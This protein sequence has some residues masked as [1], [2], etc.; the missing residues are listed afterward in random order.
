MKTI[1]TLNKLSPK[2]L[3]QY[4]LDYTLFSWSKQGGL[5][6]LFIES[7]KGVYLYDGD[8]NRILDFSS[9]LMNMMSPSHLRRS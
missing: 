2:E 9:Q 3:T 7:A 1:E 8:G 5:N 4:N 6:P